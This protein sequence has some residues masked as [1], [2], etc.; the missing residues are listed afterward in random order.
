[1]IQQI[2]ILGIRPRMSAEHRDTGLFPSLLKRRDGCRLHLVQRDS[3]KSHSIGTQIGFLIEAAFHRLDRQ[4]AEV[5]RRQI[6][7]LLDR[8]N[9][10]Q[11]GVESVVDVSS[12]FRVRADD[13]HRPAVSI[14]MIDSALCIIFHHENRGTGPKLTMTVRIDDATES[15]IVIGDLGAR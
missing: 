1:V 15:Q 3:V 13:E 9:H 11:L 12:P 6:E 5:Q 4:V 14:H 8:S 7:N 2:G 10:V